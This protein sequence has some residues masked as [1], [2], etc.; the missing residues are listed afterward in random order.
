M[1]DNENFTYLKEISKSPNIISGPQ[2]VLIANQTFYPNLYSEQFTKNI[3]LIKKVEQMKRSVDETITDIFN[4]SNFKENDENIRGVK[5]KKYFHF[6]SKMK[7]KSSLASNALFRKLNP[8][9]FFGEKLNNDESVK[10][11]I[12]KRSIIPHNISYLSQ[13]FI[14]RHISKKLTNT[15]KDSKNSSQVF[16]PIT[17]NHDNYQMKLLD[18]SIAKYGEKKIINVNNKQIIKNISFLDYHSSSTDESINETTEFSHYKR[19]S[20][21]LINQKLKNMSLTNL[22]N[23]TTYPSFNSSNNNLNFQPKALFQKIPNQFLKIDKKYNSTTE[24][25]YKS[26]A[27]FNTNRTNSKAFIK[28]CNEYQ[29]DNLNT[30]NEMQ[31]SF[32]NLNI[33]NKKLNKQFEKFKFEKKLKE[34]YTYDKYV[35]MIDFKDGYKIKK[36]GT[37]IYNGDSKFVMKGSYVTSDSKNPLRE[38]IYYEYVSPDISYK[39]RKYIYKTYKVKLEPDQVLGMKTNDYK[40]IEKEMEKSRMLPIEELP[41]ANNHETI[42]GLAYNMKM[43]KNIILKKAKNII[44]KIKGVDL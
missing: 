7:S 32:L 4:L 11:K 25:F 1:K 24:N 29:K 37:F 18:K 38:S 19:S 36:P 41:I 42:K 10:K 30:T 9:V 21:F 35:D 26:N 44:K 13:D 8:S 16:T 14:N 31:K 40:K 22:D 43:K 28:I 3:D 39:S 17:N 2:N 20:K 23:I 6:I 15:T 5:K 27:S 12:S 33:N 34:N